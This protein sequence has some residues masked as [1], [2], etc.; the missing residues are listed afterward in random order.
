MRT[1][2]TSLYP[3]LFSKDPI[4]N[5]IPYWDIS[6]VPQLKHTDRAV[7]QWEN[8]FCGNVGTR[9][10]ICRAHGKPCVSNPSAVVVS[11][12][13]VEAKASV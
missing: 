9:V 5:I 10:Q 1:L 2:M 11:S 13:K 7:T 4:S 3:S 8:V 12:N 6:G